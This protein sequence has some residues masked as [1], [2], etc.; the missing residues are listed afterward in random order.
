M[1]PQHAAATLQP[2]SEGRIGLQTIGLPY[3]FRHENFQG[4]L[5]VVRVTF[6]VPTCG[7]VAGRFFRLDLDNSW[8]TAKAWKPIDQIDAGLG[9]W[10]VVT[11]VFGL[12]AKSTL[13]RGNPGQ[14]RS[15]SRPY[16]KAA[17]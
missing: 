8:Q 9:S 3:Q 7:N 6:S 16:L 14:G 5:E 13:Q 1:A 15:F 11:H 12:L 2:E 17:F 4:N 10:T